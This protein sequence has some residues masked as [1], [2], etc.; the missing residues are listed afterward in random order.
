MLNIKKYYVH[1]ALHSY[2]WV[3]LQK[4]FHL[5]IHLVFFVA[6]A[7][8]FQKNSRTMQIE[9][10]LHNCFGMYVCMLKKK[11]F[12]HIEIEGQFASA[13]DFG[14]KHEHSNGN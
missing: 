4:L 11:H 3:G 8:I 9:S 12:T 1:I 6:K 13:F 10:I 7:T 2:W 5:Q 14:F